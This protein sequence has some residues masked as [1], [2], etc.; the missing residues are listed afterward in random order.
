[1]SRNSQTGFLGNSMS[2]PSDISAHD[3]LCSLLS[4]IQEHGPNI[5]DWLPD[6]VCLAYE[7]SE[8]VD[9]INEAIRRVWRA[10]YAKVKM[11]AEIATEARE[12]W[13][14]VDLD[15][16]RRA[17]REVQQ[18]FRD[19]RDVRR[20][21]ANRLRR[22]MYQSDE[23]PSDIELYAQLAIDDA[24]EYQSL[25]DE[26]NGAQSP[27]ALLAR[28]ENGSSPFGVSTSCPAAKTSRSE[29][30]PPREQ[31]PEHTTVGDA[32]LPPANDASNEHPQKRREEIA[33][34]E[35]Q[36]TVFGY[37]FSWDH[38]AVD[39]CLTHI[40]G[41][42]STGFMSSSVIALLN[43]TAKSTREWRRQLTEAWL[44]GCEMLRCVAE[45]ALFDI[46]DP[47]GGPTPEVILE[48]AG[49]LFHFVARYRRWCVFAAEVLKDMQA[50]ADTGGFPEG[51]ELGEV[52]QTLDRILHEL[53]WAIELRRQGRVPGIST[54]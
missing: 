21:Q 28:H 5:Q 33:F 8:E 50:C 19:S 2:Q 45:V 11:L 39:G 43:D 53:E 12:P 10:Q 46:D 3:V 32:E 36:A 37:D 52:T 1:M 22:G 48:A 14:R 42:M 44:Y 23:P 9:A 35:F 18:L 20:C 41:L 24:K 17:N 25:I 26:L 29:V 38:Y 4:I 47:L 51:V 31:G 27:Q 49:Y 15:T 16:F 6:N 40:V 7:S 30:E 13:A 34:P 54:A